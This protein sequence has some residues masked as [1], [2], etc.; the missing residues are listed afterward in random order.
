MEK[1]NKKYFKNMTIFKYL[2]YKVYY[3]KL[4]K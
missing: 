3:I 1:K 2:L 4:I